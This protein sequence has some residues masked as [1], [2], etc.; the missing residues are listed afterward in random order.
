MEKIFQSAKNFVFIGESGAGKTEIAMNFARE[1]ARTSGDPVCLYDMDQTKPLIRARE[2]AGQ[3]QSEGVTV[4]FQEQLLDSPVIPPAVRETLRNDHCRL[5]M[6]VGGSDL[7]SHM[8]GQFSND[9]RN[10]D[11]RIFFVVNPN[12]S[13]SRTTKGILDTLDRLTRNT[14]LPQ[15][16]LVSNPNFGPSTSV[17]DVLEGHERLKK[18]LDGAVPVFLCALSQHCPHLSDLDLPLLPMNL[19]HRNPCTSRST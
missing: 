1:L 2:S 10:S 5:V 7:G 19:Y 14:R 6:D 9:I 15:A 11:T 4:C 3:L 13:W 12:R 8:I 17:T 16:E 18:L